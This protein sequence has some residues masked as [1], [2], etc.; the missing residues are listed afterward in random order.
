MGLLEQIFMQKKMAVETALLA[1]N[2]N[3]GKYAS[4]TNPK[5]DKRNG[6]EGQLVIK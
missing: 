5:H 6:D 4:A 1:V 2:R 3:P